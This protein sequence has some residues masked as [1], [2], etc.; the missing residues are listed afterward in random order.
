MELEISRGEKEMG[1]G[2][3]KSVGPPGTEGVEDVGCSTLA[4]MCCGPKLTFCGEDGVTKGC[5][6]RFVKDPSGAVKVSVNSVPQAA[7]ESKHQVAVP[8]PPRG[9]MGMRGWPR[10]RMKKMG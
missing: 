3:L 5:T 6:G 9:L 1:G 7:L 2:M 10:L 8:G 4:C